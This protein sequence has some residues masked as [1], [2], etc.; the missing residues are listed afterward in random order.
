MTDIHELTELLELDAPEDFQYFENLADLIECDEEI[1]YE[2]IYQLIKDVDF[3]KLSELLKQYFEEILENVPDSGTEIYTL[4]DTIGMSLTGMS[5][6]MEEE[7][8]VVLFCEELDRFRRWYTK[9]SEV[10]MECEDDGKS[11]HVTLAEAI[12]NARIE[13]LEGSSYAYDFEKCLD[14]DIK[15]YI[16]SFKDMM[17]LA[18]D[19]EDAPFVSAGDAFMSGGYTTDILEEGFVYD[20]EFKDEY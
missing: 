14:Y 11:S 9:D 12:T 4:L 16:V 7:N 17:D 2:L 19:E 6:H 18:N 8:D 5:A 1:P 13:K 20:D 10:Y 3:K 15:E